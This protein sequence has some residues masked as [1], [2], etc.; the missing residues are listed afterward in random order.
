MKVYV[1]TGYNDFTQETTILG[2]YRTKEAAQQIQA[3][4][5]EYQIKHPT[6]LEAEDYIDSFSISETE[7]E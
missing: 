7:L 2:V 5:M 6:A 4:T 1:L 3:E